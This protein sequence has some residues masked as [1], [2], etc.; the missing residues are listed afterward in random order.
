MFEN[1]TPKNHVHQISF[2]N[3][4]RSK[5]MILT[6]FSSK[7][8]FSQSAFCEPGKHKSVGGRGRR[9]GSRDSVTT[10]HL[11]SMNWIRLWI[12]VMGWPPTHSCLSAWNNSCMFSQAFTLSRSRLYNSSRICSIGFKLIWGHGRPGENLDVVVQE[13][14]CGVAY[15]MGSGIVVLKY[16]IISHLIMNKTEKK[17]VSLCLNSMEKRKYSKNTTNISLF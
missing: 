17:N 1:S 4:F 5:F 8:Q 14:L 6:P 15:C 2:C 12:I 3:W 10:Q 11:L 13:E 16:N 9:G 7:T